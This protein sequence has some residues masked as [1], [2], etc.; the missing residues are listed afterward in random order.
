MSKNKKVAREVTSE[1]VE[2]IVASINKMLDKMYFGSD[3]ISHEIAFPPNAIGAFHVQCL[4]GEDRQLTL[5]SILYP[6]YTETRIALDKHTMTKYK[7]GETFFISD[8]DIEPVKTI[9]NGIEIVK[10][11]RR[12]MDGGGSFVAAIKK[13][14]K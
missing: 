14:R 10:E 13:Y 9:A 4:A 2:S 1:L 7:H 11:M 12:I 5:T 8:E 6:D 3:I